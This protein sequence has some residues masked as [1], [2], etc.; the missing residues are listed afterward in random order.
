MQPKTIPTDFKPM[1]LFNMLYNESLTLAAQ[2][3]VNLRSGRVEAVEILSRA[4][5]G[6][7]Q[8]D[9]MFYLARQHGVLEQL[10]LLSCKKMVD[11]LPILQAFIKRG[12]FFNVEADVS[13]DTLQKVMD[14]LNSSGQNQV[15]LEVTEHVPTKFTWRQ[16]VESQGCSVAMDDLGRGNSNMVELMQMNPHFV[17]ICMEIVDGMHNSGTKAIIIENYKRLGEAMNIEVIAEGIETYEDMRKL[18]EIGIEY[19]QG[20]YFSRPCLIE[21]IPHAEW[22]AGFREKI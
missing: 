2:P 5:G 21:E 11:S 12:I 15:V 10:T 17:K 19:G 7:L 1:V 13:K 9:E 18:R 16:I 6:V 4:P 20:Y 22:E 3:I 14:T 8:P